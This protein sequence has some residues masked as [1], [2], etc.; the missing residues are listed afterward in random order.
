MND[1]VDIIIPVYNSLS[2]LPRLLGSIIMQTYQDIKVIIVDDYSSDNYE[3]LL[4]KFSG[5]LNIEYIKLPENHGSGYA[6]NV[7]IDRSNSD[8]IVFADSDDTFL[9]AFAIEKMVSDI[10]SGDYDFASYGFVQQGK[11]LHFSSTQCNATWIFGKIYRSS[12]FN[13]YNIRFSSERFNED[14][15]FN[16][17]CYGL[18]DKIFR[19]NDTFYLHHINEQSVT[20]TKSYEDD[21]MCSF[22][23]NYKKSCEFIKSV[24]ELDIQNKWSF[25][26]GL[27]I[28]YNFYTEKLRTKQSNYCEKMYDQI[29]DYYTTIFDFAKDLIC[30][31]DFADHYIKIYNSHGLHRKM[32]ISTLDWYTF[33]NKVEMSRREN[34]D[35]L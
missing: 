1:I 23:R 3:D 26:D 5:L 25:V 6:R 18:T 21:D 14:V 22:I 20:K 16:Q 27:I 28:M 8:F 4:H 35:I 32:L 11:N 31:E 30:S 13:K 24:K 15:Y 34:L 33:I 19:A 9:N 17:I 12:F 7:G 29:T 2:T 10:S